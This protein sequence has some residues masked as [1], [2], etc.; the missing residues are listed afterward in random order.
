MGGIK[1]PSNPTVLWFYGVVGVCSLPFSSWVLHMRSSFFSLETPQSALFGFPAGLIHFNC[2]SLA[3]NQIITFPSTSA[4]A[5]QAA[6][7]C[8]A[9]FPSPVPLA[10]GCHLSPMNFPAQ[11]AL[12]ARCFLLQ[13]PTSESLDGARGEFGLPVVPPLSGARVN[14][15]TF[16]PPAPPGLSPLCPAPPPHTLQSQLQSCLHFAHKTLLSNLTSARPHF[17]MPD[18]FQG[19]AIPVCPEEEE[20]SSRELSLNL[21]TFA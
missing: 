18:S 12:C 17:H 11:I 6:H 14:V 15:L 9:R 10:R 16:F 7:G 20:S 19:W 8:T 5:M 21:D 2:P 4:Q 1:T 3:C 13:H